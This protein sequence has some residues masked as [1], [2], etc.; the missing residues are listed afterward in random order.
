MIRELRVALDRTADVIAAVPP[1][2]MGDPTPCPDM[3]VRSLMNHLVA[4]NL[5]F[6]HVVDGGDFD[7]S[8]FEDDHLGDDPARARSG[9]RPS[10]R[11]RHGSDRA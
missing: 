8:I 9:S 5:M 11:W 4:G 6:A 7:G 1:D 10:S 3:D 2:R